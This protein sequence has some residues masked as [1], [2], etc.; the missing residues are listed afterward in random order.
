LAVAGFKG[1]ALEIRGGNNQITCTWLGTLDGLNPTPNGS[2]IKLISGSAN[3]RLGLAGQPESGNL[4]SGNAG[5]AIIVDGGTNNQFYYNWI[6]LTKNGTVGLKNHGG[7]S[8]SLLG[9]VQGQLKLSQGN[10]ISQF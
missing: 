1:S 8:F 3:N 4:I 2:G 7:I 5:A 6:G 9:G 10:R